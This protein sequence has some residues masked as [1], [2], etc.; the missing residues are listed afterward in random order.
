[1]RCPH[2]F[3]KFEKWSEG[4]E[5]PSISIPFLDKR[6]SGSSNRSSVQVDSVGFDS[7]RGELEKCR[8]VRQ[9]WGGLL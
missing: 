1:M 8:G 2:V 6:C 9:S 7:H 5:S 3:E 4:L